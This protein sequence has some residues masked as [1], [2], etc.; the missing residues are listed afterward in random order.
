M[1][2]T[3]R[4][5]QL[6]LEPG[7][8]VA[9]G[10]YDGISARLIEAAGFQVAYMTGAGTC[11]SHLGLPDLGLAT[12]SEMVGHARRLTAVLKIP[13]IAD[14]DTGYGNARNV[15]RTVR[16]YERA[17]IAGFHIEDQI[18]PKRCGHLGGKGVVPI[19]EF[20]D[21]VRAAAEFRRDE[22]FVVIARTDAIAVNGIDDA[23]ERANRYAESGA[24]IVFVEAPESVEQL[25]RISR[26]VDSPLL[27]NMVA[28]G[29]SPNLSLAQV[30]ELGFK[31]TL[32]PT[33]CLS[34]AVVGIESA[35]ET[36]RDEGRLDPAVRLS[37]ADVFERVGLEELLAVDARLAARKP[38]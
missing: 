34:S 26:E 38:D 19:A 33:A 15:V 6:L 28:C 2:T 23:I 18:A 4:L 27:F 12:L 37:P 30:E 1:K 7:M 36:L 9:P 3:T 13:L 20:A 16:E 10:A 25:T 5:R 21:K 11:A 14:A 31:I 29:K 24:D 8:L 22:E 35:L 32:L 17:G